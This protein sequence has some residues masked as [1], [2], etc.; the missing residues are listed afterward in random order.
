[1][2]DVGYGFVGWSW[3]WVLNYFFNLRLSQRQ[4]N[5]L[6]CGRQGEA[7]ILIYIHKHEEAAWKG[8]DLEGGSVL[9]TS[10]PFCQF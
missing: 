4:V 10:C 2:W 7:D 6:M 3:Q 8:R 5:E 1:M 9:V